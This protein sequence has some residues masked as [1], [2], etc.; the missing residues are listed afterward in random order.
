MEI[1]RSEKKR[2]A[3][4][5]EQLA[6]ELVEL[7]PAEIRR[8]PCDTI[9]QQEILAARDLKGS[10]YK[11]Q[12]KYVAR[13]LREQE[14]GALLNFLAERRGSHLRENQEFHELEL[15]RE[16]IITDVLTAYDEARA[17]EEPLGDRWPSP[18][19]DRAMALFPELD[20]SA[21]RLA[22][23]RYVK[24]R[25]TSYSREI[26]RA[27]KIAQDHQLFAARRLK[28]QPPAE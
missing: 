5:G 18:A 9:L 26:F 27:L 11:R 1:S 21:I 19:L 17:A 14:T 16:G 3:K 28:P 13:E 23:S 10:A 12:V 15:L 8:L 7:P 4:Q 2:Q 6:F 22:A 24:N 25:K 20:E